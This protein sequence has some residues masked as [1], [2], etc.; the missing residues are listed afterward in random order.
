MGII[1]TV[2][3]FVPTLFFLIVVLPIGKGDLMDLLYK[4]HQLYMW[5]WHVLVA[6]SVVL[7][8]PQVSA[9]LAIDSDLPQPGAVS[10]YEYWMENWILNSIVPLSVIII[11][12]FVSA[13]IV[14]WDDEDKSFSL[15]SPVITSIFYLG[16]GLFTALYLFAKAD[17]AILYY[18]RDVRLKYQEYLDE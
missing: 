15:L 6:V 8:T 17:E 9:W 3:A 5:S 10:F 13:I 14:D 16:Y 18:N 11:G 4:N 7:F 12:M 1:C 2:Y